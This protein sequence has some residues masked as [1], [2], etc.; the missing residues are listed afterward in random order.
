MSKVACPKCG[1]TNLLTERRPNGNS[2]CLD[3]KWKG[4]S[5][6]RVE[7]KTEPMRPKEFQITQDP[8]VGFVVQLVSGYFTPYES[9]NFIDKRAY[10]A[11]LDEIEN[12][13]KN[14][15]RDFTSLKDNRDQLIDEI[16][17]L[18]RELETSRRNNEIK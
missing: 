4:S 16:D 10:Q 17:K 9:A 14:W 1:S 18:K 15:R 2:E 8:D 7:L 5:S 6:E 12:L 11:A 3:C 13:D